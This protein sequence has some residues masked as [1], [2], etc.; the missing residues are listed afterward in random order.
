M[1]RPPLKKKRAFIARVL[2]ILLWICG[3]APLLVAASEVPPKPCV[4]LL[5]GLGRTSD[6]MNDMAAALNKAGYRTF[7]IDYESRD[8]P[9]ETLAGQIMPAVEKRCKAAQCTTIH[10]VTH[11]MGGIVLRYYLSRYAI[12]GLGRVVM[13]SPPNQGSEVADALQDNWFY[14]WFNGPAGRQLVTGPEGITATLGPVTYPV[15]IITGNTHTIW[16]AR[17]SAMIPGDDDGKVSVERAKVAGMTDFLVV[18]HNHTF[19]M[20]QEDVI[21]QTIH[22]LRLGKFKRD[23]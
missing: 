14:E 3:Y 22:F 23:D 10:F 11:S 18:P 15:G 19:I 4:V 2:L 12:D 13:L 16:D 6:S 7:N 1:G 8:F 17:F 9:I 21:D 5:H 20:T